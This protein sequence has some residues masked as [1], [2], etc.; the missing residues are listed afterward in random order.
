[1]DLLATVMSLPLPQQQINLLIMRW[2]SC[3]CCS[4]KLG[5]THSKCCNK[6]G[7]PRRGPLIAYIKRCSSVVQEQ[8]ISD[9]AGSNRSMRNQLGVSGK[10]D[11]ASHYIE[12]PREA[13]QIY[14]AGDVHN[15]A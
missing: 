14:F 12:K 15:Y 1:M 3:L 10:V 8:C 13:S 4:L 7:S 2:F 11:S 9:G 6:K 5:A